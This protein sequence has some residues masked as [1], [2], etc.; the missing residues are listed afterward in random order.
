MGRKCDG[1]VLFLK[2]RGRNERYGYC[3]ASDCHTNSGC[4]RSRRTGKPCAHCAV[5]SECD[6][7]LNEYCKEK[8]KPNESFHVL[9]L[10]VRQKCSRI[11]HNINGIDEGGLN[12]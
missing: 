11:S 10:F 4:G 12:G 9:R 2:L 6:D 8:L 1:G 5:E 7:K 3:A